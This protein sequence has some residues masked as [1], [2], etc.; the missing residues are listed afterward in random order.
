MGEIFWE[1]KESLIGEQGHL[2]IKCCMG[3]LVEIARFYITAIR[4][5]AAPLPH[6]VGFID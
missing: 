2:I 6:C 1:H 4:E 3:V 5:K